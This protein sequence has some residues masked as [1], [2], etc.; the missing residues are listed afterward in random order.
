MCRMQR[1]RCCSPLYLRKRQ[2]T[3]RRSSVERSPSRGPGR[4]TASLLATTPRPCGARATAST[5]RCV[6]RAGRAHVP[7]RNHAL[8]PPPQGPTLPPPGHSESAVAYA[9]SGGLAESMSHMGGPAGRQ[10]ARRPSILSASYAE[11]P[12]AQHAE[13]VSP[14]GHVARSHKQ[15]R[16]SGVYA[17]LDH[18]RAAG[19]AV[20]GVA[21]RGGMAPPFLRLR[22]F[23][24]SIPHLRLM[25][26]CL[27][28]PHLPT[29]TGRGRP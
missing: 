29:P 21:L 7:P 10:K 27:P 13:V 11:H 28:S 9:A 23:A 20:A 26:P 8:P 3:P 4:R 2:T 14:E 19:D 6:A 22:C 15:R 12:P 16:G 25:Y 24:V 17:S 5:C 18:V 1:P